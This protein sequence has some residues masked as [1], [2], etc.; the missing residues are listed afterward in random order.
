MTSEKNNIR[1]FAA[2]MAVICQ[3][4]A[5]VSWWRGGLL[6][7]YISPFGLLFG[8]IG[9][10]FPSAIK[11][12]FKR[13]MIMAAAVGRFQT[14]LILTVFFYIIITPLGLL[15]RLLSKDMMDIRTDPDAPTYWKERAPLQDAGRFEKQF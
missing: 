12:I 8:A 6:Y 7:P 11:P 3:L 9:I 5:L 1:V 13:W 10:A 14:K 15:F 2:G 4:I